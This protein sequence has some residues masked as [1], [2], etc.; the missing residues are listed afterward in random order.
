MI[1]IYYFLVGVSAVDNDCHLLWNV[2]EET[3]AYHLALSPYDD[4]L[5]NNGEKV[6]MQALDGQAARVVVEVALPIA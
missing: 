3:V 4:S 1:I 5:M 6:W 2:E